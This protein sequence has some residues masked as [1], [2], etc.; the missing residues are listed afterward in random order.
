MKLGELVA[1]FTDFVSDFYGPL[2]RLR[3]EQ[4]QFRWGPLWKIT[5]EVFG[6]RACY[7][8]LVKAIELELHHNKVLEI[9]FNTW[10]CPIFVPAGFKVGRI[11]TWQSMFHFSS[12]HDF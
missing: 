2:R 12:F 9:G 3:Q 7:V 10:V 4:A 6:S 5:G 11:L 8:I 1:L